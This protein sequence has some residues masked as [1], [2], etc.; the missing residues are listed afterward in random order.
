MWPRR[1]FS[2]TCL[3]PGC[4]SDPWCKN[5]FL[6]LQAVLLARQARGVRLSTLQL[7]LAW[8]LPAPAGLQ[9]PAGLCQVRGRTVLD[10]LRQDE[11]VHTAAGPGAGPRATLQ[12][13]PLAAQYWLSRESRRDQNRSRVPGPSASQVNPCLGGEGMMSPGSCQVLWQRQV[14]FCPSSPHPRPLPGSILS[15]VFLDLAP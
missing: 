3:S 14:S 4:G 7:C 15:S 2:S 11:V 10:L 6:L 12:G 9:P 1:A 13:W 8:V 5:P